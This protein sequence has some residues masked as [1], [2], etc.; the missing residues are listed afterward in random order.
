MHR[1]CHGVE[2]EEFF[3]LVVESSPG[4]IQLRSYVQRGKPR[5]IISGLRYP[6]YSFK[7]ELVP[8]TQSAPDSGKY[9]DTCVHCVAIYSGIPLYGHL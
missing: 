2:E 5:P 3:L 7:T 8:A 4:G 6:G 9:G 1:S